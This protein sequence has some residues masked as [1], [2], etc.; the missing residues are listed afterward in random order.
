[1]TSS[2]HIS[3]AE[4]TMGPTRMRCNH[5]SSRQP[6]WSCLPHSGQVTTPA[7]RMLCRDRS[8][9]SFLLSEFAATGFDVRFPFS[10][11]RRLD[12]LRSASLETTA[13][14]DS[15][16]WILPDARDSQS[17]SR[18]SRV[19]SEPSPS[20]KK[21]V[22]LTRR[23]SFRSLLTRF[24]FFT[25]FYHLSDLRS[26]EDLIKAIIEDLDYTT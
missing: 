19:R 20:P 13:G 8:R 4:S 12:Q 18:G 21:I 10:S 25:R 9:S 2:F 26:R 5:H 17:S 11:V 15:H 22:R 16:K 7:F 3:T 6:R 24:K 23:F 1:M 14:R